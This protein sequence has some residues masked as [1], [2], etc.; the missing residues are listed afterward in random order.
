MLEVSL[1]GK[2]T[3]RVNALEVSLATR[4]SLGP[5]GYLALEG[6][7]SRSKHNSHHDA[8]ERFRSILE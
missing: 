4:K 3:V 7:T 6:A 2:P 1:F 5:V 8:R